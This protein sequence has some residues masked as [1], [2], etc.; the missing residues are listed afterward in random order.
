MR[1]GYLSGGYNEGY[2]QHDRFDYSC[3]LL[4]VI[5]STK[6]G[7]YGDLYH[8]R[9]LYKDGSPMNGDGCANGVEEFINFTRENSEHS[10]VIA[11]DVIE[12]MQTFRFKADARSLFDR[13]RLKNCYYPNWW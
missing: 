12:D 9:L 2:S 4:K 6:Q 1:Y 13:S 11:D 3:G 10:F 7:V 5:A 8:I